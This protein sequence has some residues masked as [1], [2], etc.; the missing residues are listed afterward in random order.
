LE[1]INEQLI[2][3]PRKAGI[4]RKAT[5]ED[6]SKITGGS[7]LKSMQQA[8]QQN[9]SSANTSTGGD[10]EASDPETL[11]NGMEVIHQK[12]GKG[13]I[14]SIE[15]AGANRKATVQFAAYGQK[16]LLLKF[17]RLKIV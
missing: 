9:Q 2:D 10:F 6:F 1:E 7:N 8:T 13:K 3:K 5:T 4:R 17:A 12:F 16:Q 15:G 11:Q 14:V